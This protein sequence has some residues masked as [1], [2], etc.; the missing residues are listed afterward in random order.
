MFVCLLLV[1][2]S[3]SRPAQMPGAQG[4]YTYYMREEIVPS[5]TMMAPGPYS[6]IMTRAVRGMP[7]MA[8]G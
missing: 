5:P 8:V 3:I 6:P 1:L 7:P 2:I 4:A